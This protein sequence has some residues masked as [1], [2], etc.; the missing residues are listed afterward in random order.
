M[1]PLAVGGAESNG[2]TGM[3]YAGKMANLR[4]ESRSLANSRAGSKDAVAV[5]NGREHIGGDGSNPDGT[6]R[7]LLPLLLLHYN[8]LK[9]F[10]ETAN[11]EPCQW[12]ADS[13]L[14]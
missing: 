9:I 8:F 11:H 12:S 10:G 3:I 2:N 5:A 13:A 14:R 4:T 1:S 6:P 7:V